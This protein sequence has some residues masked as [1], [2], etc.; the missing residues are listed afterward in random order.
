MRCEATH[1]NPRILVQ[2]LGIFDN[3]VAHYH[4]SLVRLSV[5]LT[6]VCRKSYFWA[7]TL[8]RRARHVLQPLYLPGTPTM[9]IA[10]G[11]GLNTLEKEYVI[12]SMPYMRKG[13]N[14]QSMRISWH[15]KSSGGMGRSLS[16]IIYAPYKYNFVTSWGHNR[17]E[18]HIIFLRKPSRRSRQVILLGIHF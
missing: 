3:L 8:T 7:R 6:K 16:R 4:T 2:I 13:A 9:V 1:R 5:L 17:L 11:N 18:S 10:V 14:V 15:P 12:L